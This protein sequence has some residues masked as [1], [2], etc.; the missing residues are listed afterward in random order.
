MADPRKYRGAA[1]DRTTGTVQRHI[2]KKG[3]SKRLTEL[4]GRFRGDK[5]LKKSLTDIVKRGVDR[6]GLDWYNTEALRDRFVKELGEDAGNAEWERY[7]TLMGPTSPNQAVPNNIRAASYWQV[8]DEADMMNRLDEFAAG[9]MVPPKGSGYGSQTQKYQSTLL[10]KFF[11]HGPEGF[12]HDLPGVVAPKPRGFA[13]SLRGNAINMAADK[14]FTRMMAMKA[15]NPDWLHGSALIGAAFADDLRASFPGINRFIKT[16]KVNG[17]PVQSFNAKKA[18]RELPNGDDLV[19]RLRKEPTVWEDKPGDNE[20]AAFEEYMGEL[21]EDMGMTTPQLQA[22]FWVG[23]AEDTGVRGASLPSFVDT[24]YTNLAKQA[25]KRGLTPDELF[26][27]FARR[28]EALVVPLAAVGAGGLLASQQ[29]RERQN[30]L[31]Y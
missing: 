8:Q 25:D 6:G 16:R 27:R 29:E 13:Q 19:D 17:K 14:H 24:F 23:A 12:L 3:T 18:A 15:G 28:K 31:L 26:K 1:P 20:Y 9:E 10:G 4:L 30:G 2:A 22:A 11:E 21:A 5:K 7:M